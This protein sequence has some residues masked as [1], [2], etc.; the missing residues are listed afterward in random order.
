MLG[1]SGIA[2]QL[3]TSRDGPNSMQLVIITTIIVVLD[4]AAAT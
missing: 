3:A 2:A 1:I 4:V